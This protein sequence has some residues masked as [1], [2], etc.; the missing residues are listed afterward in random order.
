MKVKKYLSVLAVACAG[1]LTLAGCSDYDNGYNENAIKFNEAFKETF[2]DIDPDQDWNLAERAT[3]TVNTQTTSNIKIYAQNGDQFAI[4]GNYEGVSGTQMLGIDVV[5]GTRALIVSDGHTAQTCSPGDVVVFNAMD[6]RTT[7]PGNGFVKV[8]KLTGPVDDLGDGKIHP[9]YVYKS[10]ADYQELAGKSGYVPEGQHNL[11]K[12]TADFSYVSNGPFIIYPYHWETSS[13]NTIGVYYYNAQG[14]RVD[15]DIYKI[16]E[17]NSGQESELM[18]ENVVYVDDYV[19]GTYNGNPR[20]NPTQE[21]QPWSDGYVWPDDWSVSNGVTKNNFHYNTWSTEGAATGIE[22]PYIEYWFGSGSMTAG[23][24]SREISGLEPGE[25]YRVEVL[26]RMW[27]ENS[28]TDYPTGIDFIVNNAKVALDKNETNYP[29]TKTTYDSHAIVYGKSSLEGVADAN[30]KL[31]VGFNVNNGTNA[32]WLAFKDLKVIKMKPDPYWESTDGRNSFGHVTKGLGLKVD[33][34]EGTKFGMYLKKADTKGQESKDYQFFSESA[35]NDYRVVGNGVKVDEDGNMTQ[36]E[37]KNPCY[38]STFSIGDRMFFGFEDWPNDGW[39]HGSPSS[40]FDYNDMVFAVE[41]IVP[42]II[43]ED[44]ET[45]TWMLAC[46]DLGG[47]F[48]RDYNDVVF[49]V[50]HV[51]GQTVAKVTPLAAGGTL[52]SY[53]FFVN[54][55]NEQCLGEIHQLFGFEPAVS[56]EH[57]AHNVG[58]SRGKEGQT[59]NITVPEDWS[60]A[61]CS[62]NEYSL[63]QGVNDEGYQNMGGFE[64]RTLERGTDPIDNA[65][66][67]W[68]DIKELSSGASRIPAPDRGAAPYIICFPY[69]YTELNTPSYGWKT[70]TFWAWTQEFITIDGCYPDFPKWVSNHETNGEWYKN[71]NNNGATVS[72]LKIV[73]TSGG[74]P[75]LLPSDLTYI[76]SDL[77]IN[78]GGDPKIDENVTTSSNGNITYH[79][80]SPNGS[81]W[82]TGQTL[83]QAGDRTVY[84]SQEADGNYAAGTTQFVVHIAKDNTTINVQNGNTTKDTGFDLRTLVT[85]TN[86]DANITYKIYNGDYW[87]NENDYL[88][89]VRA[90]NESYVFTPDRPG[91]L[92][93]K[94]SQ[95]GNN[96][97][98]ASEEKTCTLT[99]TL[100]CVLYVTDGSGDKWSPFYAY[101]QGLLQ[102]KTNT[103]DS[104][105]QWQLEPAG[106]GYYYMYNVAANKYLHLSSS[107]SYNAVFQD[108]KPVGDHNG[109]FKIVEVDGGIALLLKSKETAGKPGYMGYDELGNEKGIYLDKGVDKRFVFS[110]ATPNTNLAKQR[111]VNKK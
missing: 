109:K 41:G 31:T 46:E 101:S 30:G 3:V 21:G 36:V 105:D 79:L 27:N 53:I 68:Q 102:K 88:P 48:D 40:D 7:Y 75:A 35:L 64:I 106:D 60:M 10:E 57:E 80:D 5:E 19:V 97:F 108:D 104:H 76:Q 74:S 16:K 69:S 56:G 47:T 38:A 70:E 95:A 1:A 67:N 50:E 82:Q 96:N 73:T 12:V 25:R 45:F 89:Y 42:T 22:T 65:P 84:V 77:Y 85:S 8:S 43:N 52:A 29:K 28:S 61:Y 103:Y 98:N 39:A 99:V 78:R 4:V 13:Y 100:N 81:V 54:G 17:S 49:K 93:I 107:N 24:L 58:A 37:G 51:S 91:I 20:R 72:E 110:I 87:V 2:G 62:T 94:I 23:T 90:H 6:T 9:Q 55:S 44:P 32:T 86:S 34:P 15:V 11:N 63:E 111:R 14:N 18:Y 83:W 92:T 26:T 66:Q 33:I 71:K 59:V